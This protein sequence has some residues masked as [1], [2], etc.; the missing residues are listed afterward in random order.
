[1]AH[2]TPLSNIAAESRLSADELRE[3]IA[4]VQQLNALTLAT[5]DGLEALF[6]G[7]HL[8]VVAFPSLHAS[9]RAA[10]TLATHLD[11]ARRLLAAEGK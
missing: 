3:L 5:S 6:D 2:S 10:K 1:M 9:R 11:A 7:R 8:P 4:A